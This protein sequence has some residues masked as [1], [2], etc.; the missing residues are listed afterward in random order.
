M[1]EALYAVVVVFLVG[2]ILKKWW[3][4]K[5]PG[6]RGL[7]IMGIALELAQIP[8]RDIF[9]KIDSL[10][11]TYSGIFEMKIMTDSYVMLT[12]PESVE[13][14]LSSSKHIKKGI[15]DYK[16]WRLF[17]GDGLLLSDGAKWHHRRKVLTPT[18]HF[19]ILEDAMTSLVKNAQSLTEQFLDTEGKPT[20]VGNII[21]SSTLKVICETAMGVKLNTD[22]ETQNKYVEAVK[23]I[24]EA[25]ILRYLKFWLHSDFVYNLTKDGRNFKKDL[26]LAHSFTKKI[27]SERRMLYKN[28]KADNSENKSKKKAFLDC[29]LEM[30]EALT[31][32]DICEEVDTFMFEGHDTTSANLVFSL[33]LLANHPEE[34]EKVV[35]E[36][37]EIFG[38]TDRPPTLSDLAK[39]NYLEMVIKESLR[40]YPSVPLISRSLTEDLKLGAD[41]IIPAGYTAVVAPFLVHR[42]KTHWENPEEFRPER[43]MPGTPRHPF[44]FIPFSA[45]PRNCIGQKF[46]MME[47]KTMLSSVLRKCKLEAVTK[48]VNILPTGII[49]SE[50]TILMKIYKRNL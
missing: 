45:G 8:P 7:P 16:F 3:D 28:Q 23:R 39:M 15:F 26:N 38:E 50:E 41:V 25:I 35:E 10:R 49:K 21:R 27:I 19:K 18:F 31:D 12:D 30:G 43:F 13:P 24:P 47:L 33:F 40:L 17:L 29:L 36:L 48:E 5:I 2:L 4:Q 32:Q 9:A 44:A 22:D 14:L 34:Q 11:Q 42:S 6:P 46:A 1:F 37:I 20:D